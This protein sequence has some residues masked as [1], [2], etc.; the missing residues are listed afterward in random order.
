MSFRLF[1]IPSGRIGLSVSLV[2]AGCLCASAGDIRSRPLEVTP[3]RNSTLSTNVN[4]S[5]HVD[6]SALDALLPASR[7]SV[8]PDHS[9]DGMTPMPAVPP[10]TVAKKP[11]QREKEMID[12]RRNW[13]FMTPED[14]I[15]DTQP[16]K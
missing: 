14:L 3:S 2:L 9:P 6:G 12:R 7:K 16:G 15:L 1:N 10:P 13:V 4:Q 8:F 5:R 11:T